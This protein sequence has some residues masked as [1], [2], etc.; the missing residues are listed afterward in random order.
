MITPHQNSSHY[1][2]S[3]T[4]RFHAGLIAEFPL[5]SDFTVSHDTQSKFL[6]SIPG[7][8]FT[9]LMHPST[10]GFNGSVLVK[11]SFSCNF[12]LVAIDCWILGDLINM[13]S[14]KLTSCSLN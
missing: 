10:N 1:D 9:I 11:K 2:F 7:S 4:L 8:N 3:S 6:G 5:P 14:V 13:L 12:S